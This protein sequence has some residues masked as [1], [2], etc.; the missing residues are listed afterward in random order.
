MPVT[1]SI[2]ASTVKWEPLQGAASGLLKRKHQTP[3]VAWLIARLAPAK[4]S[5]KKHEE[6]RRQREREKKIGDPGVMNR[7][8][9]RGKNCAENAKNFR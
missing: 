9:G 5:H 7:I 1:S 2:P 8:Y 4:L 6:K 3:V